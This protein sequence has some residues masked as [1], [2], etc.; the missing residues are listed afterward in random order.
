M[1]LHVD[2][3]YSNP[4]PK[5]AKKSNRISKEPAAKMTEKHEKEH[6]KKGLVVND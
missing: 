3:S 4:S 2:K 5:K 6:N 1:V